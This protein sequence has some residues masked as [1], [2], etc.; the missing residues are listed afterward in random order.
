MDTNALTINGGKLLL[1]GEAFYCGYL[2]AIA[3]AAIA[4]HVKPDLSMLLTETTALEPR[5]GQ[6]VSHPRSKARMRN[7]SARRQ[8]PSMNELEP[9]TYVEGD[10]DHPQDLLPSETSPFNFRAWVTQIRSESQESERCKSKPASDQPHLSDFDLMLSDLLEQSVEKMP[11]DRVVDEFCDQRSSRD[12]SGNI[13]A[14][15]QAPDR[16]PACEASP[17]IADLTIGQQPT[18][19]ILADN[20]AWLDTQIARLNQ[21]SRSNS[22]E[23][24]T[25][26]NLLS[27]ANLRQTQTGSAGHVQLHDDDDDDDER[28]TQECPKIQSYNAKALAEQMNVSR[29]IEQMST[30]EDLATYERKRARRYFYNTAR[31]TFGCA[32]ITMIVGGVL[33][34]TYSLPV[35]Y[36]TTYLWLT[37][38]FSVRSAML[39]CS[40]DSLKQNTF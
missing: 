36:L 21:L 37:V 27:S 12:I 20:D 4:T 6:L 39:F 29:L 23:M 33:T 32:I 19:P 17:P 13:S 25:D 34:E 18:Q 15:K 9:T 30:S 5:A 35:Q 11:I 31:M 16:L 22:P 38:M 26:S 14:E 8:L 2:E 1:K 10:R 24:A 28:L 40:L 3:S 7:D